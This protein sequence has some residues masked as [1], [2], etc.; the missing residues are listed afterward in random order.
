MPKATCSKWKTYGMSL[1]KNA[2]LETKPSVSVILDGCPEDHCS[3]GES[4]SIS[5]KALKDGI[6]L[7]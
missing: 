5:K 6:A 1:G 2:E 4:W 7:K 3:I